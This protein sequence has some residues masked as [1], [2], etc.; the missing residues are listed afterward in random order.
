MRTKDF[1]VSCT[2]ADVEWAQRIADV[3]G[4][5]GFS[6]VMQSRDFHPGGRPVEDIEA[7]LGRCRWFIAVVSKDYL[8]SPW[9]KLE[10]QAWLHADLQSRQSKLITVR[11]GPCKPGKLLQSIH[12][13]DLVGVAD[14][15]VS[16]TLLDGIHVEPRR[17]RA[18]R[19][20]PAAPTYRRL[21]SFSAPLKGGRDEMFCVAFSPD[22]KWVAA[23]SNGKVLLWDRAR[24]VDPIKLA[25]PTSYVYS[26]AFSQKENELSR[27]LA[28]GSEDCSVRVWDL[29]NKVP[30][31]LW[32][33]AKGR[34]QRHGEAVYAVA[35]SPDGKTVVSGGYDRKLNLWDT[36]SGDLVR[37]QSRELAGMGRVSSVAFSPDPEG[38]Y[39]AVGSLDN[40][41][42]LWEWKSGKVT[43]ISRHL[44]SVES[45]AFSPDGRFVASCGL[46]KFVRV[47]SLADECELW[48]Y[49]EHDYLV[50]SVAYSPDGATPASVGWDKNLRIWNALT[51]EVK[52]ELPYPGQDPW[53]QDWIWSVAFA[54]EGMLLATSGSD[55]RVL[56]WAVSSD[57]AARA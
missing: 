15:Q 39:I 50:R 56:L 21:Q 3:L 5:A 25:G 8:A 26:V 54:P 13:I 35:F 19:A 22:G 9:C 53:H 46:D 20:P 52:F 37:Q 40:Q 42:R 23:G 49:A 33:P 24:P 47:W 45:V 6:T 51:G 44:S 10:W 30:E 43:N 57:A 16:A 7:A 36:A 32:K 11:I 1:F 18:Q 29:R 28:A 14:E 55:S 17:P 2:K 38:K 41:V 27:Y 31:L 48:G 4:G 12:Y 34:E